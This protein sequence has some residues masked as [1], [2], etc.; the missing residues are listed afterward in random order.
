MLAFFVRS[1]HEGEGFSLPILITSAPK[2][3]RTRPI[4]SFSDYFREVL[5]AHVRSRGF[6]FANCHVETEHFVGRILL[7]TSQPTDWIH[8]LCLL[9]IKTVRGRCDI[10][11]NVLTSTYRQRFRK[12]YSL[13]KSKYDRL[14]HEHSTLLFPSYQIR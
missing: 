10:R 13:H 11:I 7:H 9:E 8:Y 6:V 1:Y 14:Y 3:L 2:Q 12:L 5:G 4:R